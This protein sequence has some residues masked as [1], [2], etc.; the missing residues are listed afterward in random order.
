MIVLVLGGA[1]SGKSAIAEGRATSLAG[2]AGLVHYIATAAPGGDDPDF[3]ERIDRHR[4]RRPASWSTLEAGR[5]ADLAA[6]LVALSGV[7]L[8]DSLGVWLAG[9]GCFSADHDALG[10]ALLERGGHTVLVSEEVGLGV[11]PA[12]ASGR[13][14][15]DALG[16]LNQRVAALADEVLLAVAGRALRLPASAEQGP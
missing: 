6:V 8:V 9:R 3:A 1:R 11:H 12:H 10:R 15:R 2:P 14:F 7:V 4:A 13:L 16:E 5:G